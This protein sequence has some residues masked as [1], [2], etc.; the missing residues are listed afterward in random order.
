MY[1][2][3]GI[4]NPHL[5]Y[6]Y[7]PA[8]YT[9]RCHYVSLPDR[10]TYNRKSCIH[11]VAGNLMRCVKRAGRATCRARHVQGAPVCSL[12]PRSKDEILFQ[13]ETLNTPRSPPC[14]SSMSARARTRRKT[15]A[16]AATQAGSDAVHIDR[17]H[18]G[19]RWP[20][21]CFSGSTVECREVERET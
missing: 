5:Q 10:H 1:T 12:A 3:S 14:N 15:E 6:V 11:V 13:K 18:G 4:C 7:P 16:G 21:C 8:R 2:S 17:D 20:N 19:G 9:A